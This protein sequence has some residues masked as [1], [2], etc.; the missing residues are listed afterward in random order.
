MKIAYVCETCQKKFF[1][2]SRSGEDELQRTLTEGSQEGIIKADMN[3]CRV[4]SS[5]CPQCREEAWEAEVHSLSTY[6]YKH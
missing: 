1:S 6:P 3:P 4:F 5:L 2:D